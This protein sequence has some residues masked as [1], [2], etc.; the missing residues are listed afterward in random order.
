MKLLGPAMPAG[1]PSR[2]PRQE[3]LLSALCL[4]RIKVPWVS[5]NI[6]QFICKFTIRVG[7]EIEH[8]TDRSLMMNYINRG[9]RGQASR[10]RLA[11]SHA[12]IRRKPCELQQSGTH[13]QVLPQKRQFSTVLAGFKKAGRQGT[14]VQHG[15]T[16]A[17]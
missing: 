10:P 11:R 15:P 13:A 17:T 8:R 3:V 6:N 2:I 1:L 16:G 9:P 7:R 12:S 14:P 5:G 4:F